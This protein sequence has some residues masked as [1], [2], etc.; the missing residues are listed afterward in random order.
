MTGIT[1]ALV[2]VDVHSTGR[3]AGAGSSTHAP[4]A[5]GDASSLGSG[6]PALEHAARSSETARRGTRRR[7]TA[8]CMGRA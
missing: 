1:D 2:E 3:S 7:R 6:A 4:G 8:N 5:V